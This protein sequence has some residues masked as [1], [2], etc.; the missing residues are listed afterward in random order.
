MQRAF[1]GLLIVALSLVGCNQSPAPSASSPKSG[2]AVQQKLQALAG[3][4]ATDCGR[5]KSQT[6]EKPGQME[7]ASACAMDAAKQKHAFYVVYELPGMIVALAGNSEGK[8]FSVQSQQPENAPAG[9]VAELTTAPCPAELRIA[10]S[11]RVTCIAPGS[12]GG[13]SMGANPHGGMSMPPGGAATPHGGM[14]M[15]P[16]GT[17]NPHAGGG[18]NLLSG[19]SK[20]AP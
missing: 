2:D 1:V 7:S 16:P 17:P 6:P 4:G 5:L 8:L 3:S 10:Q 11:G 9:T 14:S 20:S 13:S 19:H 15:P 18:S 12:F